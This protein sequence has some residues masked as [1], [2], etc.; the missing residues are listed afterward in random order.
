MFTSAAL[1]ALGTYLVSMYAL[2]ERIAYISNRLTLFI[3]AI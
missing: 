3:F 2:A 1:K